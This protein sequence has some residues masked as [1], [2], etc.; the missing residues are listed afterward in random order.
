MQ[1]TEE[2]L[3]SEA[4]IKSV[5]VGARLLQAIAAAPGP[6]TLTRISNEAQM[7]TAKARRYL[8]G[9]IQ[10]GLVVQDPMSHLYD[11]GPAAL[12]LGLSAISRYDVVK[13]AEPVLQRLSQLVDE[14]V[15]LMVWCPAGPML[16]R[17]IVSNH[18]IALTMRAGSVLPVLPSASGRVLAAHM[19]QGSSSF[20]IAKEKKQLSSVK[21][22]DES[23]IF[24]LVRQQGYSR[25]DGTLLSGVTAFAVPVFGPLGEPAAALNVLGRTES[26]TPAHSKK[27]IKALRDASIEIGEGQR[28]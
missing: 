18:P 14:T 25:V 19:D 17:L 24:D 4:G 1:E 9:Y 28:T 26:F 6:Q 21:G 10:A 13:K 20:L 16:A 23:K 15:G 11:L 12:Q 2:E 22:S 27:V 5:V 3:K 8:V 7:P